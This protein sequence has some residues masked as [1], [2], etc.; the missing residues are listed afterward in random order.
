MFI[1]TAEEV[2]LDLVALRAKGATGSEEFADAGEKMVNFTKDNNISW[3][4]RDFRKLSQEKQMEYAEL[5]RQYE[6]N[7]LNVAY[8]QHETVLHA[9]RTRDAENALIKSNNAEQAE[10]E[11]HNAE[12]YRE[13]ARVE[14]AKRK[15]LKEARKAAR[16]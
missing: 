15:A 2:D 11:R 8:R 12:V 3:S 9:V 14:K 10:V 1:T 13:R 4:K 6:L 5:E 7:K 16:S